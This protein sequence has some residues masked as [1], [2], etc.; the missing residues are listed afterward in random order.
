MP[1]DAEV[2]AAS[3]G[4]KPANARGV[5]WGDLATHRYPPG[6]HICCESLNRSVRQFGSSLRR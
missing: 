2:V 3:N 1:A 6:N 4:A 5:A